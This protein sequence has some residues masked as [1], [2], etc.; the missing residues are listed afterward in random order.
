MAKRTAKLYIK[1]EYH[2]GPRWYPLCS[3][4]AKQF[5]Y[6]STISYTP[7]VSDVIH[8]VLHND[9]LPKLIE[10]YKQY[11][12]QANAEKIL[13]VASMPITKEFF[14]GKKAKIPQAH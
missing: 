10:L 7:G 3:Y 1:Q 9:N 4:I 11:T 8:K 5:R 2:L 12:P 6:C 13:E 14:Y